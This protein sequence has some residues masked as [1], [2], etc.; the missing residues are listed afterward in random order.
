MKSLLLRIR[1]LHVPLHSALSDET[2]FILVI[3][4]GGQGG[5]KNLTILQRHS[6]GALKAYE[7]SPHYLHQL[8]TIPKSQAPNPSIENF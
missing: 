8:L 1:G 2:L 4:K 6:E 5:L 3:Q 7:E